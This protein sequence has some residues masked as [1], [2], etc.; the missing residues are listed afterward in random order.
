MNT[1]VCQDNVPRFEKLAK[2]RKRI[3]KTNNYNAFNVSI[4]NIKIHEEY[5]SR[6]N[7][8]GKTWSIILSN[9]GFV[10]QISPT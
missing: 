3:D 10:K 4:A 7:I 8:T 1:D 5:F 9:Y 6:L 2:P